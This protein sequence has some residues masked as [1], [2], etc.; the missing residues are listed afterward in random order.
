MSRRPCSRFAR[1]RGKPPLTSSRKKTA[2]ALRGV[3]LFETLRDAREFLRA[4]VEVKLRRGLAGSVHD[5]EHVHEIPRSG[6]SLEK[7]RAPGGRWKL[8]EIAGDV[9]GVL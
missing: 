5:T 4:F 6:M 7:G 8:L 3:E 1:P 2:S 9:V